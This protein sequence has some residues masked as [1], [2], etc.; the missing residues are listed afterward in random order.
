MNPFAPGL[1]D[2]EDPHWPGFVTPTFVERDELLLEP[3][4]ILNVMNDKRNKMSM[5]QVLI[6]L[7]VANNEILV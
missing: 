6:R 7:M 2:V 5:E 4:L 1:C 3:I